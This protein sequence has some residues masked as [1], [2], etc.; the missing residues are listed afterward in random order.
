MAALLFLLSGCALFKST[1]MARTTPEGLYQ[2][3]LE[4]YQEG[5]YK[6][7]SIA[8]YPDLSLRHVGFLGAQPPAVKGLAQAAFADAGRSWVY[9]EHYQQDTIRRVFQRL[10]D[11]MIEKEG[12]EKA[13]QVISPW[14][15]ES[16]VVHEAERS[17]YGEPGPE[18]V[19]GPT[20]PD[21]GGGTGMREWLKQFQAKLAALFAEAETTLPPGD[22]GAE[23]TVTTYSEAD[24]RAREE[25]AAKKAR[26]DALAEANAAAARAKRVA[27]VKA[28]VL[29]FVEK[30]LAAGTFLPAWREQ[31][32]PAVLEQALLVETPLQFA[33]GKDPK[34]PGE[35]LLSVFEQL[36]QVVTFKEVAPASK[37]TPA[38]ET[39]GAKL[40]TL[41]AA[42]MKEHENATYSVAF[43]EVQKAH[44]ELASAYAEE[45]RKK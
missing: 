6:K 40:E 13:D 2:R 7:V 14:D 12:I 21:G 42:Y 39:A 3:G 27:D 25:A 41:T 43:A 37:A 36:P 45:V 26:E 35:I 16:L 33:E 32:V 15:C 38:G 28:R 11:W 5:R 8:L 23:P 34:N 20:P 44:P 22:K 10:R 4:D 29:A 17:V 31:G 24:V 19:A 9:L 30:G 18:R 1:D